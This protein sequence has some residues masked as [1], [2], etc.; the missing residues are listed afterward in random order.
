MTYS[1]TNVAETISSSA[2]KVLLIIMC[3]FAIIP[4]ALETIVSFEKIPSVRQSLH[5]TTVWDDIKSSARGDIVVL[6]YGH[7]ESLDYYVISG[8][9]EKKG[10]YMFLSNRGHLMSATP[11]IDGKY[12]SFA[13]M[14]EKVVHRGSPEYSSYTEKYVQS[15]AGIQQ[16]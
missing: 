16:K 6:K 10:M 1:L 14:V 13:L 4:F 12:D 15:A 5:I 8:I 3:G 9:D 2:T 11:K 7:D